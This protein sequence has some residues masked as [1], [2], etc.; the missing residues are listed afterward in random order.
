MLLQIESYLHYRLSAETDILLQIEAAILPDQRIIAP[1]LQPGPTLHF[2]RVNAE[3]SVGER[4]WMRV[5]GDFTCQYRASVEVDRANPDLNA[6]ASVP[7]HLLP[8][9]VVQYLMPSRYC[10]S[11]Q[12]QNFV[13]EE[14]GSL[15][16]G[17]RV[18]AIADWVARNIRY[19]PGA[20]HAGTTALDTFVQRQGI[21]RDFAHVMIAMARAS[22]IPARF[23]SAYAPGVEPPDFHAVV[24]VFLD[25][26]WQLFDPTGMSTASTIARIGVGLDAAET[27][28]LTSYGPAELVTQTV[29]VVETAA[30]NG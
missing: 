5:A 17:A 8:G 2:A 4:I 1:Y 23:V 24:E 28:F 9:G 27:A 13:I 29:S 21:C 14:F 12:F 25:G 19:V 20:S 22:T 18:M 26:G 10:P 16:G 30:R 6:L 15:S 7:P 3:S 11:D